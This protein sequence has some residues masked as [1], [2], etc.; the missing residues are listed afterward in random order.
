MK[1]RILIVLAA[2]A[3]LLCS[4]GTTANVTPQMVA[5]Y[6]NSI[7]TH[8]MVIDIISIQPMKGAI[9]YPGSACFI[10]IKDGTIDGRLPFIG[11]AYNN[12][13]SGEDVSYV[14]NKCPIEIKENF[15]KADKGRYIYSFDAMSGKEKVSFVI[16][17]TKTG[18]AD[19]T[20]KCTSRSLMSYTGQIR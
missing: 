1:K 12:L 4:C 20:V 2:L 16:N 9:T 7:T 11:D 13:F 15:A 3:A 10:T 5:R 18:R 14:F 17:L 19:L 8:D 6:V